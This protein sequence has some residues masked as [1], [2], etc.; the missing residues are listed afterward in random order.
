MRDEPLD[1]DWTQFELQL[2]S[3][4]PRAPCLSR[5]RLMRDRLMFECGRASALAERETTGKSISQSWLS[6]PTSG[7][8][9]DRRQN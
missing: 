9:H 6:S 2:A 8:D 7:S 4:V 5:N 3:L 1:D